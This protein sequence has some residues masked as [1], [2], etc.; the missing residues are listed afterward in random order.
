MNEQSNTTETAIDANRL[1]TGVFV[2][3]TSN[4]AEACKMIEKLSECRNCTNFEKST[5]NWQLGKCKITGKK[6][7]YYD[8]CLENFK[9][10]Q[11]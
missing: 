5:N 2:Y 4:P 1:L 6:K 11:K 8:L 9:S 7:K 3:L 10:I